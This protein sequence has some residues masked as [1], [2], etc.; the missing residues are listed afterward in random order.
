MA[1]EDLSVSMFVG[2]SSVRRAHTSDYGLIL[3]ELIV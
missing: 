2:Y 1:V 3:Y